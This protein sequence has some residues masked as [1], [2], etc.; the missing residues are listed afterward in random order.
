[1]SSGACGSAPGSSESSDC[2]S[3]ESSDCGSLSV[4][5]EAVDRGALSLHMQTGLRARMRRFPFTHGRTERL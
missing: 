1:M 2:G 4:S 5:S 3:S